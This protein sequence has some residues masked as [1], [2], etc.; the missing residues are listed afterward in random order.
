MSHAFGFTVAYFDS[1]PCTSLHQRRWFCG[2]KIQW[3]SSGKITS[4]LGT[5]IR[6]SAVNIDK[7]SVYGTRKSSSPPVTSVGVL[8]F[9]TN[10]CGEKTRYCVAIAFGFHGGPPYSQSVNHNSSVAV[11]MFSRLNGPACDTS[12]LNRFVWPLIQFA[13]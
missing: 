13:M 12:A 5:F 10:R 7:C 8:K 11:A 4:R 2:F 3:P 6:W 1:Q 9:F